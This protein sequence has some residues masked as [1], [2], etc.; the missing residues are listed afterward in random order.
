M[1]GPWRRL[2]AALYPTTEV[3]RAFGRAL[4]NRATPP[5]AAL[6]SVPPSSITLARTLRVLPLLNRLQGFGFQ[7]LGGFPFGADDGD[8]P[9][10][11][12]VVRHFQPTPHSAARANAD[13]K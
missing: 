4:G 10:R 7:L 13:W 12:R 2:N 8:Q 3:T 5:E 1:S 6:R 11:R 9:P